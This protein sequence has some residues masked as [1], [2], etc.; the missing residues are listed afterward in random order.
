[1]PPRGEWWLPGTTVVSDDEG[2][3]AIEGFA[4]EYRIGVGGGQT[5]VNLSE[6]GVL[7]RQVTI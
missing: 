7:K 2:R 5:L 3:I 6:A 1:V 4:G